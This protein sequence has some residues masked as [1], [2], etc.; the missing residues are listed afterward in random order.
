MCLS[1]GNTFAVLQFCRYLRL[2]HCLLQRLLISELSTNNDMSI[3]YADI[4]PKSLMY[5]FPLSQS[6]SGL[7]WSQ[8]TLHILIQLVQVCCRLYLKALD[9]NGLHNCRKTCQSGLGLEKAQW[10]RKLHVV[11]SF[12]E[13]PNKLTLIALVNIFGNCRFFCQV[14]KLANWCFYLLGRIFIN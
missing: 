10:N 1:F 3:S 6:T 8:L 7:P 5:H 14:S 12:S 11:Y 4:F 9:Y 2:P 13:L